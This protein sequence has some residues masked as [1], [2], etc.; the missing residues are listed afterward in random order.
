MGTAVGTEH[1]AFRPSQ[2]GHQAR[3]SARGTTASATGPPAGLARSDSMHDAP[4]DGALLGLPDA[5]G[6]QASLVSRIVGSERV[7]LVLC[8]A[9]AVALV[10]QLFGLAGHGAVALARIAA[11]AGLAV[12]VV[13]LID[14]YS[15]TTWLRSH[16][17]RGAR[18]LL[19]ASAVVSWGVLL[20]SHHQDGQLRVLPIVAAWLLIAGAWLAV[21]R[22][23][24]ALLAARPERVLIVGTGEVAG[25]IFTLSCRRRSA[26]RVIGCVDDRP[27]RRSEG[28]PPYLG[29]FEV[30]PALLAGGRVDRVIVAFT[31]QPDEDILSVLR[32]TVGYKCPVDIVPRLFDF[33]GPEPPHFYH[34]D[35]LGFM[36]V[37]AQALSRWRMALKRLFDICAS[38]LLL[39]VLSPV[40]MA[41]ALVILVDGGGP[42]F[43]RQQRAGRGGVPFTILKFRTL[44]WV[45]PKDAEAAAARVGV[46]G[47]V[48][49]LF[50]EDAQR[51]VTRVGS[52]LR[53]TSLDELPQ[54]VNILRGD[55]SLI[56]P[57]PLILPEFN[58]L[59]GW[60]LP[61]S[62][63]APWSHRTVASQWAKRS[64]LAKAYDARPRSGAPL[65]T[66]VRS[67]NPRGYDPCA[68]RSAWCTVTK[69]LT[70]NHKSAGGPSW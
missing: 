42:V 20:I 62:A 60:E 63:H 12:F 52:F 9:L 46:P 67:G 56:G 66:V 15:R 68:H 38:A 18:K 45:D 70:S 17:L 24:A 34:A 31:S 14:G 19:G 51:R 59:S 28:Q 40:M 26:M 48:V 4:A 64:Q 47:E 30:L 55:M 2:N 6:T 11:V 5:V 49:K 65:V 32:D 69:P 23:A 21:R 10:M 8:D 37:Q 29:S 39:A 25:R 16:P 50:K 1:D 58:L 53:R 54:L 3:G 57:R 61:A 43:F 41:I 35:G 7:V 27:P 33:L 36:S 22:L 44:R 13:G